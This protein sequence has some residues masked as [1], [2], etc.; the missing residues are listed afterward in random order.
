MKS[1]LKIL[2]FIVLPVLSVIVFCGMVCGIIVPVASVMELISL[3]GG[4]HLA[5]FDYSVVMELL[6]FGQT[7]TVIAMLTAGII[8]LCVGIGCM[9]LF[10][11]Y[12]KAMKGN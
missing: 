1:V 8:A 6:D 10:R 9:F 11:K 7:G 4:T 5:W 2:S 3:A 12:I